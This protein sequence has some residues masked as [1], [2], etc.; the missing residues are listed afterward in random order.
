VERTDLGNVQSSVLTS[1]R[2]RKVVRLR[3]LFDNPLHMIHIRSPH[4]MVRRQGR[5]KRNGGSMIALTN[6]YYLDACEED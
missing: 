3:I 1:S 4:P 2:K 5:R 6:A